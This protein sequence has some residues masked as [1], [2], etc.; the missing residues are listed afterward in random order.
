LP[1]STPYAIIH[2]D[3]LAF[4]LPLNNPPLPHAG[5][6]KPLIIQK[7]RQDGLKVVYIGDGRSDREAAAEADLVFA[8]NE[9][10]DY[11]QENGIKAL[12]FDSFLDICTQ[13]SMWM[14]EDTK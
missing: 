8:K 2:S 6:C 1:I 14:K 12:R 5:V 9:L 11:C 7:Y 3:W 10:A 4:A 13:V